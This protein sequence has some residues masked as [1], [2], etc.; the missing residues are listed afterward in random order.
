LLSQRATNVPR[1]DFWT[2]QT[3][4][5]SASTRKF[6]KNSFDSDTDFNSDEKNLFTYSVVS[7]WPICAI[8]KKGGSNSQNLKRAVSLDTR[9]FSQNPTDKDHWDDGLT[10]KAKR[11]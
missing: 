3:S 10:M 6:E 9:T 5:L 1:N 11:R 2:S 8:A 4:H 7:F